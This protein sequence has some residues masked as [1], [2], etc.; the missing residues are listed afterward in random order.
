ME[1][2]FPAHP[3]VAHHGVVGVLGVLAGVAIIGAMVALVGF[4]I[5]AVGVTRA[6]L[7]AAREHAARE[8]ELDAFLAEVLAE[9][10]L[11]TR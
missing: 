2:G 4:A 3:R 10:S 9:G 6:T 5:L 7:R 11:H 1:S 8:A